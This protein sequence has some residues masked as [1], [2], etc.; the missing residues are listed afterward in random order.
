M[1]KSG[2][3]RSLRPDNKAVSTTANSVRAE[4]RPSPRPANT[5]S[6]MVA[7]STSESVATRPATSRASPSNPTLPLAH[8]K[9]A[10]GVGPIGLLADVAL[11]YTAPRKLSLLSAPREGPS[12]QLPSI[13][14]LT[15]DA[16]RPPRRLSPAL[17]SPTPNA[18]NNSSGWKGPNQDAQSI[19][20]GHVPGTRAKLADGQFRSSSH[21]HAAGS[22]RRDLG[23]S[24]GHVRSHHPSQN[25][26]PAQ[27]Q[28]FTRYWSEGGEWCPPT[29]NPRPHATQQDE[30]NLRPNTAKHTHRSQHH[31]YQRTQ[32]GVPQGMGGVVGGVGAGVSGVGAGARRS[33]P[34]GAVE[35][36]HPHSHTPHAHAYAAGLPSPAY[37]E[38]VERHIPLPSRAGGMS[39]LPSQPSATRAYAPSAMHGHAQSAG[40]QWILDPALNEGA[41]QNHRRGEEHWRE[42]PRSVPFASSASPRA[43]QSEAW[44]SE[45]NRG[46]KSKFTI[47]AEVIDVEESNTAD[48]DGYDEGDEGAS[49]EEEYTPHKRVRPRP[50]RKRVQTQDQGRTR[51][52]ARLR[53]MRERDSPELQEVAPGEGIT[54]SSGSGSGSANGSASASVSPILRNYGDEDDDDKPKKRTYVRRDAQRRKEQNAQAQKKFRWKKKVMAEQVSLLGRGAG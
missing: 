10:V 4:E 35:L 29:H 48:D 44:A 23:P 49:S 28:N 17:A 25:T 6:T 50:A 43:T 21:I 2:Q 46:P 13:A 5:S 51:T 27:D 24:H 16:K 8:P 20:V 11:G 40:V 32:P 18:N 31:P 54:P 41:A 45:T 53:V 37:S 38:G 34:A 42:H 33:V 52:S 15:G 36:L 47:R 19:Q 14:H 3:I 7:N 12:N 26:H 39:Q 22:L 1:R 30:S 9:R